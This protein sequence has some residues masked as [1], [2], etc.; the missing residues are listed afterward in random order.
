MFLISSTE[1]WENHEW[2][3]PLNP[4]ES[5]WACEAQGKNRKECKEKTKKK[6]KAVIARYSSFIS[7]ICNYQSGR[8]ALLLLFMFSS[9]LSECVCVC[10]LSRL[11]TSLS[12]SH[13]QT[14]TLDKQTRLSLCWASVNCHRD[15]FGTKKTTVALKNLT[16]MTDSSHIVSHNNQ[17]PLFISPTFNNNLL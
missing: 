10:F 3:A 13:T 6:N 17:N 11:K 2:N 9:F 14:H 1:S 8:E 15:H 5:L 12:L 7:E 16:T 4:W